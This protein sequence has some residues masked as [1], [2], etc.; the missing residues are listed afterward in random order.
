MACMRRPSILED[1][2][3]STA[4]VLAQGL[5]RFCYTAIV[6]RA[7][8]A[9]VLSQVNTSFAV[10][11]L[12]SLLWPTG[13][14]NI[15]AAFLRPTAVRLGRTLHASTAAALAPIGV[16]AFALAFLIGFGARDAIMLALL[17]ISWSA[18]IYSRGVRFGMGQIREAA[19][20]DI[21]TSLLSV[22]LLIV[23]V[24][25]GWAPIVLLPAV[26][27]YSA[28][29]L[30]A[31]LRPRVV[32]Q[33]PLIHAPEPPT[34]PLALVAWNSLTLVAT[35]GLMQL[36]MVFAFAFDE[37]ASAGQF[38]AALSLATPVS[39]LSQ[40]ITQALLPRFAELPLQSPAAR[41]MFLWRVFVGV[42]ALMAVGCAAV[43]VFLPFVLPLVY[44]ESFAPA[45]P[46]ARLLMIAVFAFSMALLA[47]ALLSATQRARIATLLSVLGS[48][49]GVV[50]ML[51]LTP[52]YGGSLAA[53][54]GTV[55]GTTVSAVL[56]ILAVILGER[57][58]RA[59]TRSARNSV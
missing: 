20:W 38:A 19:I 50:A 57:T 3:L 5:S 24:A 40:A 7:F 30:A 49:G 41:R 29:V 25:A 6:A 44:G 28:F 33:G 17:A 18:Y 47:A 16:V 51:S 36:S 39:M 56:L 21:G 1:S 4:G 42:G 12:L 23:T 9:D 53:A 52:V 54:L 35:N 59:A 32:P 37:S 14:G 26:V 27:A 8:G 48:A 10:A 13:A 31:F 2:A 45:V 58:S 43:A 34:R 15:A 22:A 46:I 55:G 11:I